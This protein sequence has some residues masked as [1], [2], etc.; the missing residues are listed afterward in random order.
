[1]HSII[2]LLK[3]GLPIW[4]LFG[5]AGLIKWWIETLLFKIKLRWPDWVGLSLF[6]IVFGVISWV[7]SFKSIKHYYK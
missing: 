1:M 5:L 6:M 3:T 2:H 4:F 7:M